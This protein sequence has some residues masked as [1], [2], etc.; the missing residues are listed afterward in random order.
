M[1]V[2]EIDIL[3][4]ANIEGALKEFKKLLP[5]IK[6]QLSGIQREFDNVNLKDISANININQIKKNVQE[7]K[8]QIKEAFDPND[9]SGMTIN[10]QAFE[11]KTIK[12]YSKEV[13]KLTGHI[14][15]LSNANKEVSQ[16]TIKPNSNQS[17]STYNS[18]PEIKT[19]EISSPKPE[20]I[21]IWEALRNKIQQIKPAIQQFKQGIHEVGSSKELDL[22]KYQISE[23]EEKLE[24][25]RNGKIHLDYGEIVKA[26]ADLERLNNKKN[27]LEKSNS[28]NV[29]SNMISGAGKLASKLND[30]LKITVRIKN[31]IKGLGSGMKNGVGHVM[32]YAAAL[33]SLR[34]IYSVL[35]SAAQ[36]WLSSQNADAKQLSANIEY[37]KYAMGSALAPVIQ[38][39]TNL[40]YQ[41]MKAV[42]SVA[43]ALT[44]VNIFAKASANSYASM[45][46]NAKKAKEETKQLAGIH[47]DINNISSSKNSDSGSGTSTPSLDLSQMDNQMSGFA[48]KIYDFF[49]PLKESWEKYGG[50]VIAQVQV[51]AGQIVNLIST[52]WQSFEAVI[53]NGTVYTTLELILAIIGNIAEAFANAWRTD[54]IGDRLIQD[55]FNTFNNILGIINQIAQSTGFQNM[56]TSALKILDSIILIINNI[57]IALQNAFTNKDNGNTFLTNISCML[58]KIF[59]V[60]KKISSNKGFQKFLDGI[61][62]AFTGLSTLIKPIVEDFSNLSVPISNI[63]GSIIG[64]VLSAIGDALKAIGENEVAITILESLA[65]AIGLVTTATTL[66]EAIKKIETK[67]LIANAV[68][69]IAANAPIILI[70]AAITAII[71]III[72][73]IKHWDE[74]K[75]TVSNVVEKIKNKIIEMKDAIV[76]KV[77]ELWNNL[78]Q[79]AKD[80][81]EGIKN[82]FSNV[83]GWFKDKFSEAWN[84]VKNVFAKG[85]E[86]FKG[87][88]EGI[89]ETFKKIVNGLIDGINKVVKVPFDAINTALR[90]IKN[91]EIAGFKPF[92]FLHTIS[93]PQIPHLATGNVAYEETMAIFGEYSGAKSNPEITAPQNV[94]RETFEDVLSNRELNNDNNS[95][96]G[97]KQLII[98]FGSTE[99]AL[100]MESLIQQAKRKGGAATVTV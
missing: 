39:V 37:M 10:G 23:I 52:V 95:N 51:T 26:E 83:T 70:T 2:E 87:I 67:T 72:L 78:K 5:S 41:L 94:L 28:K 45:A 36:S 82:V 13:Q 35:S 15:Q 29:F 73:C 65:V 76:G 53:T 48:K 63:A 3:V 46:G 80:A 71:A 6:K 57:A 93:V 86:V 9:I 66:F 89:E 98:Q 43:Y 49:K 61:V 92:N 34:G 55:I 30:T 8:K 81:W 40:V 7:A 33:F 14:R 75:E 68:A 77:T 85:G 74:I 24:N 88:K 27:K 38:F 90:T 79:G 50:Q 19:T 59:E 22:V 18:K 12:G 11:I 32:K 31:S 17:N 4:Q 91:V 47:S 62:D 60:T 96:S 20:S 54:V 42:Q 56:L 16:P 44:G 100:E 1:T 99:V 58:E 97:L 25:A 64:T 21:S 84:A 69:W